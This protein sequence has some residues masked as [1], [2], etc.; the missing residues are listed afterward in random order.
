[1]N[2]YIIEIHPKKT[3]FDPLAA[4][5]KSELIEVG[6]SPGTA[7]V[8]TRRLY[9]LVGPLKLT[10]VES[11]AQTLL[12]DPVVETASV[13]DCQ[14]KAVKSKKLAKENS[15]WIVD[16]WPK[17]GVT[18]PIGETVEKGLRDLGLKGQ[19]KATSAQR[20][21]FP[22]V[23]DAQKLKTLATRVLANDLIHDIDIRKTN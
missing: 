3:E 21:V 7:S 4:K 10:D 23:K 20:Y 14:E 13:Q 16:I 11:A 17:P 12:V 15:G 8:E 19:V 9:R 18:D 1:M 2:T 22:K 5:I 6:E